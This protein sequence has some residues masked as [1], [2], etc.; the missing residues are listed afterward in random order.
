MRRTYISPEYVYEPVYGS[1]N[2]LEQCSFLGSKMIDIEDNLNVT[3]NNL[4]YYQLENGEQM[5][6]SSESGLSPIVYDQT[7]DKSQNHKLELVELQSE[8]LKNGNA[9]WVLTIDLKT[10]LGNSVFATLKRARTF[11]G[12]MVSMTRDNDVNTAIRKYIDLNIRSR[13]KFDRVELFLEYVN[14][15]NTST[16]KYANSFDSTIEKS[17][18]KFIKIQTETE[19]DDSRIIVNFAQ[20][21]N[22]SE[23]SFKYYFNLYFKKL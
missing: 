6:L 7:F 20:Q 12:V 5:D 3:N 4:V 10:I 14:L 15:I 13:Y 22:A 9:N 1:F 17:Q 21:K 2:M 23:F 11:E 16:L 18:N 8:F 19:F